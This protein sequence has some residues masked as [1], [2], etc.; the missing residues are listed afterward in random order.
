MPTPTRAPERAQYLYDPKGLE[1]VMPAETWE[2]GLDEMEASQGEIVADPKELFGQ[3]ARLSVRGYGHGKQTAWIQVP[4]DVPADADVV[5][6]PVAT[7]ANGSVDETD[8]ESGLEI[9]VYE[10]QSERTVWTYASHLLETKLGVPYVY[11]FADV[12]S[13][14][15][16]RVELTITLRQVDVCA[17]SLCTHDAD[18]YIGDLAFERLPDVCTTEADGSH[19]LYDYYDDPTPRQVAECENPQPYYFLDV[20]NGPYNAYGAGEDTYTLSFELP[21]GAELLEFHLYYGYRTKG[22]IIN[23]RTLNPEEVYAA[24]PLHSGTY[25]NITEPSRHSP[26]NNNPQAVAPYFRAGANTIA[27]TVS[28]EKDWEERPFDL[29]ARFRV[30]SPC[31]QAI[32][33]SAR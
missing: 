20:E 24:F 27:M 16:Q 10:P 14:Q 17:G 7:S 9:A 25:V 1:P 31:N 13:F 29:F 6:I 23:D 4:L 21:N 28:A 18:F 3:V 8:S 12:S 26:V 32:P 30:P 2:E 11:A 19:R 15:S 5:S 33:P 22:L